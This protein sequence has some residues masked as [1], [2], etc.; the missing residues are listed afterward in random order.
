MTNK[1][2][3]DPDPEKVKDSLSKLYEKLIAEPAIEITEGASYIIFSDLHKGAKDGADD[4]ALAEN[5]YLFALDY[6]Y[7]K[8]Y[9][10]IHLGD[11]EELWEN[12]L[13]AVKK[14]NPKTL[15]AEKRF[16]KENRLIK[17]F[18]NHD[19]YWNNDPLSL[20]QLK[21]MYGDLKVRE[22]LLMRKKVKTG[23]LDIFLTHGHQGD[24]Q[25]DGNVFSAWFVSKIWAPLQSFLSINFNT[26]ANDH[27]LKTLHNRLMYEWSAAR[28]NLLLITGHTHQPVFTSLTY[29]EK[30]YLK[31]ER[32]RKQKDD[33][34]INKI[35]DQIHKAWKNEPPQEIKTFEFKP[36][37]FNS[38]CCC[39]DDGDMT[40]LEINNKAI[41]LV[42]WE[43]DMQ[44]KP[45][46][47]ELDTIEWE[48]LATRLK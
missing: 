14:N 9:V 39:F 35:Q 20:L 36:S 27:S 11:V 40:G 2:S 5:N 38:G 30:L 19:I 12:T 31:L 37:Y 13:I 34:E 6:Y 23:Q 25:S 21:L 8:N 26:P 42:K 1:Y 44:G 48:E 15:D 41:C 46:R 47:R 33:E 7:K 28:N 45:A 17:M 3:T 16:V 29:L 32:A 22:G 10:L 4:F 43:Y 24:G 18:G